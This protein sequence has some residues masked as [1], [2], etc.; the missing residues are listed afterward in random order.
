MEVKDLIAD[1][2]SYVQA[3]RREFHQH[4][5]LSFE[6]V[7]TTKRIAKELDKIGIPYTINP[8]RGLGLV[9]EI[10]GEASQADE[11]KTIT[12][13]ADIDGLPVKE[14]TGLS[15]ASKEE[16]KMHACGH[17]AHMAILLGAARMLW[18]VRDQIKGRVFLLFQPGEET[19]HGSN[20]MMSV[21]AWYKWTDAIFGGHVWIDL[22]VGKISVEAGERMAA[23]DI[24]TITVEG[25][26]GHGSQP[27]QTVDP[28]V[29]ASAIVMNLQT[30][31]SRN[32]NPLD[33]AVVT[34][35]HIE[36]GSSWNIIPDKAV[37]GGT[38]R[39]FKR[40]QLD[41]IRGAMERIVT[42]TA[43]AFGGRARFDYEARVQPV[44][45][46]VTMS[47]L[48]T[49]T[50]THVLGKKAL[51]LMTKVTAGE[52]FS[53]Y[54]VDKPACFAFIGIGNPKLDAVHGHHQADFKIDDSRLAEASAVYAQFAIDWLASQ[55]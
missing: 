48:A 2:K 21:G 11:G 13:R 14:E 1:H 43:A 7:E 47:A 19:G 40:E 23:S 22:P 25:K 10:K 24:F 31:V 17:D 44:I 38:A 9:A 15:Y 37:L 26:E 8:D 45:N 50:V 30:I 49:K 41:R 53:A 27:Q 32:T 12:L 20:Y 36:A 52:D 42:N 3:L 34:I 18:Q 51:S 6:E 54:M 28:I 35:G 55:G 5:E 16:G 33:S 29:I 4:P 46:D 39:Y